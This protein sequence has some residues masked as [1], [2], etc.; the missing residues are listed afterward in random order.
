[1]L[2]KSTLTFSMLIKNILIKL[3]HWQH[4]DYD[5]SIFFFFERVD[6]R[7]SRLT[8]IYTISMNH[9]M[10]SYNINSDLQYQ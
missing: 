8:L 6:F 5:S 1:M 7:K 4:Y 10:V 3:S 9:T 2:I